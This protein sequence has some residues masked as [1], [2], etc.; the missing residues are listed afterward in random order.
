MTDSRKT[1]LATSPPPP[2]RAPHSAYW[3]VPASFHSGGKAFNWAGEARGG[4]RARSGAG[5]GAVWA[6]AA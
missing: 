1:G 4:G 5:P 2:P 3:A 6:W